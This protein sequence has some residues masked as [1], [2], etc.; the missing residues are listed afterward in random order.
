MNPLRV[1]ELPSDL[2]YKIL[3]YNDDYNVKQNGDRILIYD[4]NYK[5]IL[6]E[7][8]TLSALTDHN[9]V[10]RWRI[11]N[12]VCMKYIYPKCNYH[13]FHLLLNH[14][15]SKQFNHFIEIETINM[16]HRLSLNYYNLLRYI[17]KTNYPVLNP[18]EKRII[19]GIFWD[20]C[21]FYYMIYNGLNPID[22]SFLL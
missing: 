20:Y 3:S 17:H 11:Y 14:L 21:K 18:D 13:D 9:S 5:I 19:Y 7:L 15:T 22:N 8:N 4:P 16:M 6:N 2:V 12:R 10:K 1:I